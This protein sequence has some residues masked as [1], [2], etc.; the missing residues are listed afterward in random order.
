MSPIVHFLFCLAQSRG[1]A[2]VNSDLAAAASSLEKTHLN[3][4]QTRSGP[5]PPLPCPE[6]VGAEQLIGKLGVQVALRTTWSHLR[7][8]V[9]ILRGW[10]GIP[11]ARLLGP[12][13][14]PQEEIKRH[15]HAWNK[16]PSSC[17]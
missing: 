13:R 10:R 16:G 1:G 7:E 17:S 6:E 4:G 11:I 9:H 14:N 15:T 8:S 3:R 5:L 12:L 2:K